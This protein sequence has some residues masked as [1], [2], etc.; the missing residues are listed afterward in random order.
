MRSNKSYDIFSRCVEENVY[1]EFRFGLVLK[2]GALPELDC[3]DS[4][5]FRGRMAIVSKCACGI[6]K[7]HLKSGSDQVYFDM[8]SSE[9]KE[10]NLRGEKLSSRLGSI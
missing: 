9:Q 7:K 5:P 2:R 1:Q 6:V 8:I 4:P 10:P 3:D